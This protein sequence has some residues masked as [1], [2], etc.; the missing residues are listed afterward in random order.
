MKADCMDHV[1]IQ[2]SKPKS[3]SELSNFPRCVISGDHEVGGVFP[4]PLNTQTFDCAS[5]RAVCL[6]TAQLT[7]GVMA[8]FRFKVTQVPPNRSGNHGKRGE[9]LLGGQEISASHSQQTTLR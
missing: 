2:L 1:W 8:S 9:A 5:H 6:E 4:N 3:T 7:G